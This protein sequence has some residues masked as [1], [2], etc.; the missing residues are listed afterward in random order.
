M[1]VKDAWNRVLERAIPM[2]LPKMNPLGGEFWREHM[3]R[4][5]GMSS[6]MQR[7]LFGF[8]V[9]EVE[10]TDK[11]RNDPGEEQPPRS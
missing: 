11:N 10:A 7:L 4:A 1:N 5:S 6:E 8:S 9:E 2:L 3:R